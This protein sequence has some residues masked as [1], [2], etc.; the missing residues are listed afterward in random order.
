[1]VQF[2]HLE[3]VHATS[4]PISRSFQSTTELSECLALSPASLPPATHLPLLSKTWQHISNTGLSDMLHEGV[5]YSI[6]ELFCISNL[7]HYTGQHQKSA[8]VWAHPTTQLVQVTCCKCLGSFRND[9][10]CLSLVFAAPENNKQAF[11]SGL[12]DK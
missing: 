1:M 4:V 3:S 2:V 5:L 9:K 10:V 8:Q 6:V 7:V 12:S 11:V